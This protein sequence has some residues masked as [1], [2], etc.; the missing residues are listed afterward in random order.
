VILLKFYILLVKPLSC[1]ASAYSCVEYT[2]PY[3][4]MQCITEPTSGWCLENEFWLFR[5][6]GTEPLCFL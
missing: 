3:A 6:C 1:K 5:I 4:L 2:A